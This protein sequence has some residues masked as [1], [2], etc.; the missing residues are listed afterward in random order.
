MEATLGGKIRAAAVFDRD[1]RS[2]GECLAIQTECSKFCELVIIHKRKEVENFLLVPDAI[3]RAT[4][5]RVTDHAKRAGRAQTY[6]PQAS[7]ILDAFGLEK[8]AYVAAQFTTD[9][10]RFERQRGSGDHE[11]TISEIAYREFELLWNDPAK[12][13][14]LLPGKDAL[15]E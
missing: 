4:A 3:D 2:D 7:K 11:A 8:K 6:L 12:R 14:D 9:R 5:L 10:K 15:S 1:Y 13:M